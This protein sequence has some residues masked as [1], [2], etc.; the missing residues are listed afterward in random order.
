MED[1]N[2]NNKNYVSWL[3]RD[4]NL[5]TSNGELVYEDNLGNRYIEKANYVLV[6]E[7]EIEK[8]ITFKEIDNLLENLKGV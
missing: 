3:K 4:P 7:E 5:Q 8:D 2:R 6:R 1:E